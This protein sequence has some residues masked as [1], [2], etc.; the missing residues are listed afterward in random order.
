MRKRRRS[1]RHRSDDYQWWRPVFGVTASQP[2]QAL[3]QSSCFI[4]GFEGNSKLH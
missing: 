4:S 2:D 3:V 1:R